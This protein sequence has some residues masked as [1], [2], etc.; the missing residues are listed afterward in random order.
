MFLTTFAR[1]EIG[2]RSCSRSATH[3]TISPKAALTIARSV[4][5]SRLIRA[6]EIGKRRNLCGCSRWGRKCGCQA[7]SFNQEQSLLFEGLRPGRSL[8]TGFTCPSVTRPY[9][10]ETFLKA[11]STPSQPTKIGAPPVDR[12]RRG[13][14]LLGAWMFVRSERLALVEVD[15]EVCCYAGALCLR[16]AHPSAG[17][18]LEAACAACDGAFKLDKE[19]PRDGVGG[20]RTFVQSS[21]NSSRHR[22]SGKELNRHC[23]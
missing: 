2:S 23:R 15:F 18:A 19:D 5:R 9:R 8:G 6:G 7:L 3:T 16:A 11:K 4:L 20:Q 22:S 12:F 14:R 1:S 17:R 21:K 10:D 13:V